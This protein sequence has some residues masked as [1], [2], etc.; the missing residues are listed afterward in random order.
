MLRDLNLPEFGTNPSTGI[1]PVMPPPASQ[2]ILTSYVGHKTQT[3]T[4]PQPEARGAAGGTFCR[5]S[6]P[7]CD[8]YPE[9]SGDDDLSRGVRQSTR[10][11]LN[12]EG[13]LVGLETGRTRIMAR[14]GYWQGRTLCLLPGEGGG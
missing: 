14:P 1:S 2:E 6:R 3:V 9:L 10:L 4:Q 5:K 8:L 11:T 13:A 12:T 7:S